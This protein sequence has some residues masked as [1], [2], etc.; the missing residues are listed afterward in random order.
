MSLQSFQELKME[1]HIFDILKSV[2]GN[3]LTKA[4]EAFLT[5]NKSKNESQHEIEHV[6]DK[7]QLFK[8]FDV[9]FGLDKIIKALPKPVAHVVIA[10][11][12]DGGAWHGVILVVE[13]LVTS[14]WYVS[15]QG[16]M[17]F[18][19]S[20]GGLFVSKEVVNTIQKKKI[21]IAAWVLDKNDVNNLSLGMVNWL[22]IKGHMIPLAS[23]CGNKTI[24]DYIK[25]TFVEISS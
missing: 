5:S 14:E 11:E 23:F 15:H 6:E 3:Y 21:P 1:Q 18:E 24:V 13:S 22:D 4:F 17:A 7:K 8:T 19:G 2:A 20:G 9:R 16:N 12:L 10:D 25:K